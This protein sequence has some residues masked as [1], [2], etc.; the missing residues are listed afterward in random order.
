MLEQVPELA[1]PTVVKQFNDHLIAKYGRDALD[2]NLDSRFYVAEHALWRAKKPAPRKIV[3]KAAIKRRTTAP[4]R[5][6]ARSFNPA[7]ETIAILYGDDGKLVPGTKLPA[8]AMRNF[9]NE[10]GEGLIPVGAGDAKAFALAQQAKRSLYHDVVGTIEDEGKRVGVDVTELRRLNKKIS[11]FAATR[12][13]YADRAARAEQGHTTLGNLGM[14][15]MLI[16]GGGAAG[17]LEGAIAGAALDAGRRVSMPVARGLDY[18]LAKLVQASRAGS[19]PAELGAM[20]LQLGI[21]REVADRISRGG[22]GVLGNFGDR[23]MY[24][25]RAGTAPPDQ[26]EEALP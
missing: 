23:L 26:D 17:G 16:G 25:P 14:S 4:A 11:T 15:T 5:A 19:K 8:R 20:A 2:R 13:A 18:G 6:P 9:A 1:N 24:G 12:D 21:S 10:V 3:P 22:L 7:N